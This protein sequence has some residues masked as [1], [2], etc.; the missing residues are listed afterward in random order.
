MSEPLNLTESEL[1]AW[2]ESQFRGRQLPI[3]EWL[4]E[5]LATHIQTIS[6]LRQRVEELDGMY[7][8][9]MRLKSEYRDLM[10]KAEAERDDWKQTAVERQ[11][12]CD[13]WAGVANAALERER[14]LREALERR[15]LSDSQS[16]CQLRDAERSS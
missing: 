15:E 8:E 10:L 13:H 16:L 3:S 12:L 14:G 11:R 5:L 1:E 2:R 7:R 4:R 6:A 9:Q